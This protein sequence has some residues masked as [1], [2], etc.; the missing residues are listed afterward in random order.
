MVTLGPS[1]IEQSGLHGRL[2]NGLVCQLSPLHDA[3]VVATDL[4]GPGSQGQ[5]AFKVTEEGACHTLLLQELVQLIAQV[6]I[7]GSSAPWSQHHVFFDFKGGKLTTE[8]G[9]G[10]Q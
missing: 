8:A 5:P 9:Q 7:Q 3:C 2:F 1:S 10:L 6:L 4:G